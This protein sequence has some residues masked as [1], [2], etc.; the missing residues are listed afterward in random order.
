MRKIHRMATSLKSASKEYMNTIDA[1][2]EHIYRLD[3]QEF[4]NLHK[5]DNYKQL[6]PDDSTR[7]SSKSVNSLD[8]KSKYLRSY[9]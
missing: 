6:L 5:L 9:S 1:N 8:G 2:E 7:S 3:N 4:K